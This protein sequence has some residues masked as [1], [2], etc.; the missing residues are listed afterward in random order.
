M[1]THEDSLRDK[2]KTII[3]KEKKKILYESV[4]FKKDG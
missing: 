1:W 3:Q 2:K 4:V